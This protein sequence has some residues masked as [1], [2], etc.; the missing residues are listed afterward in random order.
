VNDI[1]T[2]LTFTQ[3][4][5]YMDVIADIQML[6]NTQELDYP[7]GATGPN[8][9]SV[10]HTLLTGLGI[11]TVDVNS[12]VRGLDGNIYYL[13][14]GG[15]LV[16]IGQGILLLSDGELDDLANLHSIIDRAPPPPIDFA[17][18]GKVLGSSL[19]QFVDIGDPLGNFVA[20]SVFAAVATNLGQALQ[21]AATGSLGLG[22]LKF[23][24]T[25][26]LYEVQA[27]VWGDFGA[28]LSDV[29]QGAAVGMLSSFMFL[30]LQEA[31]GIEGFGA[32]L[33]GAVA[34]S[35]FSEVISNTT[36]IADGIEGIFNR[37]GTGADQY[38]NLFEAIDAVQMGDIFKSSIVSFLATKLGSAVVAPETQAAVILS[39]VGAGVGGIGAT[40]SL[41]QGG[42]LT[43]FVGNIAGKTLGKAVGG[44]IQGAL[45]AI[46]GAG[47]FLGFVIGSFIGNLFGRKRPAI[48]TAD[49]ETVLN[50]SSG[51]YELGNVNAQNGG[52]EDLVS[53]MA[54]AAR[55]TLNGLISTVVY[56]AEFAGNANTTSPTQIYGHTG[57]QLWVK[58]GAQS[59]AK[60]NV[61]S[62]DEAV[63]KG[64]LWAVQRTEI[65]GGNMFMKRAIANSSSDS[66]L[67]LAGDLQIAEDYGFY[68]ANSA[69]INDEISRPYRELSASDQQ[70]Y[71]DYQSRINRIMAANEVAL[72][73]SD[74]AWYDTPSN[75]TQVDRIIDGL[76]VSQFAAGWIITLQRAAE[77]GL[78]EASKSDFYGGAKGLLDSL[79]IQSGRTV[80]LEDTRISLDGNTMH[81]DYGAVLGPEA[82]LLRGGDLS[83]GTS[84][85]ER[86]YNA[87]A[88]GAEMD[89]SIE[90]V[91]GKQALVFRDDDF[92]QWQPSGH[93]VAGSQWWDGGDMAGGRRYSVKGGQEV[94]WA[95][96]GKNMRNDDA[97][98]YMYVRFMDANGALIQHVNKFSTK[99][100][101]EWTRYERT[102]TAPTNA[103]QMEVFFIL[104]GAM[105]ADGTVPTEAEYAARNFQL[106]VKPAGDT[107][108]PEWSAPAYERFTLEDVFAKAGLNKITNT[109][110]GPMVV[111]QQ[112]QAALMQLAAQ[113]GHVAVNPYFSSD[114]VTGSDVTNKGDVYIYDGDSDQTVEDYRS[115]SASM[116]YSYYE[117]G[118]FGT[119]GQTLNFGSVSTTITHTGG[120]DIFITGSGNDTIDGRGGHDWLSGGAGDDIIHGG[121]GDDVILG[122]D[123]SDKLYG[124]DGDDYIE[125]GGGR[126]YHKDV[127]GTWTPF[128]AWGGNGNDTL[129][130]NGKTYLFGEN[131]DDIFILQEGNQPWSRFHGGNGSDTLSFE[132]HT[133]G[134]TINF[135]TA[136]NTSGSTT[137]FAYNGDQHYYS[138]ENI[139]G[140]QFGDSITGDAAANVL[141]GLGGDD[142]INGGGGNDTLEGGTGADTLVGGS[143]TDTASYKGSA[144]AVWV[145]MESGDFFGADATGDSLSNIQNVKGSD[146]DDTI[147]GKNGVS[148]TFWGERG[149]DWFVASS[150]VDIIYGGDGFDTVDY[151]DATGGVNVNLNTG[152]GY[153]SATSDRY[154]DIEHVVGSDFNDTMTGSAGDEYFQGGKGNDTLSGGAGMDTYVFNR[155]DG[156]DTIYESDVDQGF[157]TLMFGDG[158]TWNDLIWSTTNGDLI[159]GLRDDTSNTSA[160]NASDRVFAS[161]SF[162]NLQNQ[163][164]GIDAVDVGG[165]GAIEIDQI[166]YAKG[167][168]DGN[169]TIRGLNQAVH[170]SRR[171][172]ML[173]YAGNDVIYGSHSNNNFAWEDDGNVIIGGRGNDQIWTSVGDDQFVFDVG[174]GRDTIHDSGGIDRIQFGSGVAAE[175]VIFRLHNGSLY[176]GLRDY[177]N[178][179][180]QAH[181]VADY[182]RV[183]GASASNPKIE[184]ITAGGVEIDLRKIDLTPPPLPNTAPTNIIR[185]SG[186]N[187]DEDAANGAFVADFNATDN[188]GDPLTFSLANN[189]GGRFAIHA[190][191]G[192][193][194]VANAGLIDYENSQSHAVRVRATDPGGLSFEKSFTINVNDVAE[195]G[196]S[197]QAPNAV[198][199]F[200]SAEFL[201]NTAFALMTP[202]GNDTDPDSGDTLNV[203][204]FTQT[205]FGTLTR[206][207]NNFTFEASSLYANMSTSFTYT[208]TDGNG[209]FDTATVT[210]DVGSYSGGGGIFLYP[211]VIDLDGDGADL[212]SVHQSR[213]V[214]QRNENGVLARMG[215]V[216][217]D[218]GLLALDRDG[219][220][221]INRV[222][223]ISFVGDLEGAQTDL[224]G[225]QA[226][227]TDGDGKLTA[228]DARWGDFTIWQDANE[229][230]FGSAGEQR[231]LDDMGITQISLARTPTGK[232]LDGNDDTV[233]LN[234]TEVTFADG[235]VAE[236]YDT[237]FRLELAR[238]TGKRVNYDGV[239][240]DSAA[241]A[242]GG[243]FGVAVAEDGVLADLYYQRAEADLDVASFGAGNKLDLFVDTADALEAPDAKGRYKFD[244]VTQTFGVAPIVVDM[245][246]DGVELLDPGQ[247]PIV[248]DFNGDG[249]QDRLGWA[250]AEDAFLAFDR[251]KDGLINGINEIS[252]LEDLPGAETDLQGLR[253]FDSNGNGLFDSGD[254]QYAN[255]SLW[256]DRNYDGLGSADELIS[257]ADAGFESLGL[258]YTD[259]APD[260]VTQFN[261]VHGQAEVTWS[262]GSTGF[263]GDISLQGFAGIAE[264][265]ALDAHYRDNNASGRNAWGFDRW[266]RRGAMEELERLGLGDEG[267]STP[268]NRTDLNGMAERPGLALGSAL[269]NRGQTISP[270]TFAPLAIDP[271]PEPSGE[272]VTPSNLAD[273]SRNAVTNVEPVRIQSRADRWWIAALEGQD[274]TRRGFGSLAQTLSQLESERQAIAPGRAEAQ[275]AQEASALAEQQRLLQAMAS[276]R[277]A[278]GAPVLSRNDANDLTGRASMLAPARFGD[279]ANMR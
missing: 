38:Q 254:A 265:Q 275:P 71:S 130:Q 92:H 97:R 269:F 181:Q 149:D 224:E 143:G 168:W 40:T 205:S 153:W 187:V 271:M 86:R 245:D 169:D 50:F 151:A 24:A 277:G 198:N 244:P 131:D 41:L 96:E 58:L 81:V 231:S 234:T 226:F 279:T 246:G 192:V 139:T 84:L 104:F 10:A 128:G 11:T 210:I 140:S 4:E 129:V 173:G 138:M 233:I 165:V 82:N 112:A 200:A 74:Q 171:D 91:D 272:P 59:A 126:D 6:I 196:G 115:E 148:G 54:T 110:S 248:G 197:N 188:E 83:E 276:F 57:G 184:H 21:Q 257:L 89:M 42:M 241:F 146:F 179:D 218:D 90:T 221:L 99:G 191:T 34:T 49:A 199:D 116:M 17:Q 36:G 101:T 33:T 167:G 175:D 55:D 154:Y 159:I 235:T 206:N 103:A 61:D 125:V 1:L 189:A 144:G 75:K 63:D 225:L 161:Q 107:S 119:P 239:D 135:A 263:A 120:D 158:V 251:N 237:A 203:H 267:V 53:D 215:W 262:D 23:D 46:P 8:S 30:E 22:R 52:N 102:Y 185:A 229:N 137:W 13:D 163:G 127:N 122:G 213:V 9:N 15:S 227:D 278:S 249:A 250:N 214:M 259:Q 240:L 142:T 207:G 106:N 178:P 43:N 176:I 18:L 141:R 108:I 19:G 156:R 162:A 208:V 51:Y 238:E 193:L 216:G 255:F 47:I 69:L 123:G 76:S 182:I 174:D 147:F 93:W 7:F 258:G 73:S 109:V 242:G 78:N 2:G 68:L 16:P 117:E 77:L 252:F 70:F 132:R 60:Q 80:H 202:V 243:K 35:V 98:L 150:G 56:G 264:E 45:S 134:I 270:E 222:D 260:V 219:D 247:S 114:S 124:Q 160:M 105:G 136:P 145:D 12:L 31:L 113:Q 230:G 121:A 111:S 170:G 3:V 201:G 95:F 152:F 164:G 211:V 65:V 180:L 204:S 25:G 87:A 20:S 266:A 223:E 28:D 62:A 72:N 26:K 5:Q 29:T 190:T 37:I 228:A 186:G 220:G 64:A 79:Q 256:Q 236:G 253:A 209:G 32:E 44:F 268:G 183:V 14:A 232:T 27:E 67:A 48:P 194:S 217:A 118:P 88:Y 85:L 157:D 66:I 166:N 172:L 261:I 94:S 177:E 273:T 274:R 39:S 133:A 155:G 212:I 195:G 100:S